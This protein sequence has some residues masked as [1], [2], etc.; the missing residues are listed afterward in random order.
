MSNK[1]ELL[2][3]ETFVCENCNKFIS[4]GQLKIIDIHS[5]KIHV[6]IDCF[7]D[8]EERR[9]TSLTEADMHD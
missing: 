9:K 2:P 3:T 1:N 4:I 6:C 7:R 5:I 8:Y